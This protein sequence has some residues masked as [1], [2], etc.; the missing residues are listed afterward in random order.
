MNEMRRRAGSEE[1]ISG[2]LMAAETRP[3][4]PLLC[5]LGPRKESE[6]GP[7]GAKATPEWERRKKSGNEW[8][9][10]AMLL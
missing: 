6:V 1:A 10:D 4:R 3:F 9:T 7:T 2:P 5:Q 8:A